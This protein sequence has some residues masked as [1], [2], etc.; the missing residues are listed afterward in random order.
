[1]VFLLERACPR[2]CLQT[3]CAT[4]ASQETMKAS[5]YLPPRYFF[6]LSLP[7]NKNLRTKN[8]SFFKLLF[9][10]LYFILILFHFLWIAQH[11]LVVCN[12]SAFFTY[13]FSRS[14]KFPIFFSILKMILFFNKFAHFHNST[15]VASVFKTSYFYNNFS[16]KNI[17][18]YYHIL[19]KFSRLVYSLKVLYII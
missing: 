4:I 1:M 9:L 13:I 8:R 2:V 11:R 5:D 6:R 16:V 17:L 14:H 12:S 18:L 15:P 19:A 10:Y 7:Y 3:R